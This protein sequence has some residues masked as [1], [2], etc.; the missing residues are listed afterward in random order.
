MHLLVETSEILDTEANLYL[1]YYC[2]GQTI[3]NKD[4]K[5]ISAVMFPVGVC[6]LLFTCLYFSLTDLFINHT[7]CSLKC[8]ECDF[9]E[10]VLE[11]H[12]L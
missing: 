12:V 4:T 8:T 2:A 11:S 7:S 1:T 6:I 9:S 5:G 10:A 3:L